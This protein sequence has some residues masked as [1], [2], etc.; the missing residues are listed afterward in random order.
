[1]HSLD[2]PFELTDRARRRAPGTAAK[3]HRYGAEAARVR[4]FVESQQ[5]QYAKQRGCCG[6]CCC[7]LSLV[8][9]EIKL[10]VLSV[11][12]GPFM[13]WRAALSLA[14]GVAYPASGEDGVRP[15]PLFSPRSVTDTRDLAAAEKHLVHCRILSFLEAFT[16][17][18]PQLL[19]QSGLFYYY[20]QYAGGATP[21]EP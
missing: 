4:Q 14:H 10:L 15:T 8:C 21:I 19:L 17:S 13:L 5:E 2:T 3:T 18:T 6:P 12:L 20:F 9:F 1:M 7:V 16:E 11:V